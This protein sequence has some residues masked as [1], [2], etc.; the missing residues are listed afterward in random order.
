ME[1]KNLEKLENEMYVCIRCAYCFEE[2]PVIRERGWDTDGARGK[3]MLSYGLMTGDLEAT[4]EVADRLFQC[5][6]CGDCM[7]RC[8]SN[9]TVVD[10]IA[11]ARADLVKAGFSSETHERVIQNVKDTGNIYGD[12][13]GGIEGKE[14]DTPL[15]VG[16]QYQSRPNKTKKFIKILEKLGIDA[17]ISDEVC[18]G[19]PMEI[20][21]FVD[22][23]D[24]HKERF[25]AAFPHGEAIT[26]CP[27]CTVFLREGHDIEARHLLQAILEVL[28]QGDLGMKVTYHDPCDFSRG[29][30][31][32]DEP[33][34]IIKR[35]GCELIEMESNKDGSA[36]CGGG[37]GILMS[38]QELSD[39]ISLYRIR[40]AVATGAEVLVTTCSTCETVLKKAAKTVA[41]LG[42]DTITVRNIED[43]IW[44]A[45]K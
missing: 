9:V 2:C 36:C 7:E 26:M 41:E 10:I 38:D 3:V 29:L 43:L 25:K 1:A 35:L 18:C 12:T 17:T 34:E 13:E 32:I 30:K 40:Q 20:L 23:F 27:T 6:T 33:R 15:F 44:K 22:D 19:F 21:G 11:A 28:P 45:L 24:E 14:G 5:T 42:E 16:C 8:P 31:I 37:G 4:Q 39:D